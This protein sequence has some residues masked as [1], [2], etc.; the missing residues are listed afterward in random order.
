MLVKD[1]TSGIRNLRNFV[2]VLKIDTP[3][4]PLTFLH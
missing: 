3:P 1:M 2:A 4:P